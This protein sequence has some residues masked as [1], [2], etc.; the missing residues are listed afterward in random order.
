M[1]VEKKT[2][3]ETVMQTEECTKEKHNRKTDAI[4]IWFCKRQQSRGMY[5]RNKKLVTVKDRM[6]E[7]ETER[8][9]T[10]QRKVCATK[11]CVQQQM[12]QEIDFMRFYSVE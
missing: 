8:N 11:E 3:N 9:E 12:K 1:C 2:Q 7:V 10:S 4:R 6:S 5:K